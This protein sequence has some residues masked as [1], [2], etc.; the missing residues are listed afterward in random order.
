MTPVVISGVQVGDV[1]VLKVP[2][3]KMKTNNP[4]NLPYS[5]MRQHFFFSTCYPRFPVYNENQL[6]FKE[7]QHNLNS[8]I[9][10]Y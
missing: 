6:I 8:V 9:N 1:Y 5:N 3:R 2:S 7:W 4:I 10:Q